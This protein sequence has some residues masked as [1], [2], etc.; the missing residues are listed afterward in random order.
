MGVW[1]YHF[2]IST[3]YGYEYNLELY[4]KPNIVNDW[5]SV[6]D[7]LPD[8]NVK[9]LFTDGV[10]PYIGYAVGGNEKLSLRTGISADK[11]NSALPDAKNKLEFGTGAGIGLE[12]T[13]HIQL[14]CQ[15]FYN[16]GKLY[17][18]DK[19]NTGDL[20]GIGASFTKLKNYQGVKFTLAVLF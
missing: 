9:V 8:V 16:F 5:I 10:E 1:F 11:I 4:N 3:G 2:D 18:E 20:A 6:K 7:K 14:S 13:R 19:L 15:Y 12:I 17:N